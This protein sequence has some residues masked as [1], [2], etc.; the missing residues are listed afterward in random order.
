[1]QESVDGSDSFVK[2][3][4][5]STDMEETERYDISTPKQ[6]PKSKQTHELDN[7][8]PLTFDDSNY[9]H[10]ENNKASRKGETEDEKSGESADDRDAIYRRGKHYI[11]LLM[12][13]AH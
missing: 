8:Q 7:K 9:D 5:H 10:Q 6:D 3:V 11:Q 4:D 12:L 13:E 1:M 2:G